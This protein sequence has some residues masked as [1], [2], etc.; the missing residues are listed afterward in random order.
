[1]TLLSIH[2]PLNKRFLLAGQRLDFTVWQ[3][4]IREALHQA[5]SDFTKTSH[6]P[7]DSRKGHHD[8]A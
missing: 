6:A 3:F 4:A 2:D 5:G 7:S 1:M 8:H